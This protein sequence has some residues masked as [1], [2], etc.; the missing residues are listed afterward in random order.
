M[1]Q[2]T[3]VDLHFQ[4][5]RYF[6]FQIQLAQQGCGLAQLGGGVAQQDAA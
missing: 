1:V 5:K 2:K 4:F 3:E 6:D